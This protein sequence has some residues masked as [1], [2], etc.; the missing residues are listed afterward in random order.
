MLLI[1]SM[2]L[3]THSSTI[4]SSYIL[5]DSI[6]QDDFS[7]DIFVTSDTI[8][9]NLKIIFFDCSFS[10]NAQVMLQNNIYR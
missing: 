9:T 8:I 7:L 5:N 4:S 6:D 3:L 1:F 10:S 2:I